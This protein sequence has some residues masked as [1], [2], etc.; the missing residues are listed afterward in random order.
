MLW[1]QQGPPEIP[2]IPLCLT[3]GS[4]ALPQAQE[5]SM[6]AIPPGSEVGGEGEL[7]LGPREQADL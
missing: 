7:W 4:R 5:G 6:P 3:S 2:E 1:G